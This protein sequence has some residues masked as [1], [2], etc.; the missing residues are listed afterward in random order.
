MKHIHLI[1]IGGTGLSAIAQVLL[2][3]GFTVSGSDREESALFKAVRAA[4]ASTYLGHAP[5]HIAGADLVIRSSAITDDNPEVVAA[6]KQGIPVL[7]RRDFLETLTAGKDTLAIAG[8]HG[9]TT[10][11]AMLIWILHSLGT[12]PSFIS[13]GVVNQLG[14]NA[15][16]GTGPYF[17]IEADEYDYMFL[18]LA[19]KIAIVTNIEHDHPDCFPTEADYQA[20]FTAFIERVLPDGKVLLCLDDPAARSLKETFTSTEPELLGYGRTGDAAYVAENITIVDGFPHFD[21]SHRDGQ[22][23]LNRLGTVRLSVPGQH[24]VLNATAALGVIHLLNLSISDAIQTLGEFTG[25]GRRFEVLGQ[26]LG[27]TVIDDYGHHPSEI[28]ATLEAAHSRYSGQRIWAVWQPH[29]YSRTQKLADRFIQAIDLADRV[30][31]L[32]VY[33]ARENN[34]GYS[35]EQITRSLPAGKAQYA[36]DFDL[37]MNDLLINLVSGDVVVFFS[38]GDATQLSQAVLHGLQER[39]KGA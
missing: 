25:A 33:A 32:K 28:A 37:A 22:G 7:K 38:A 21:L 5:E 14:S 15:H 24:N 34:P 3:R 18:G 31:V 30:T 39:E 35:A 13:G 9:K 1:G 26:A 19:P 17:V 10:T 8:S 23:G 2:E 6:L 11:T 29:T 27:V 20:A 4:G 16:A 12:D 36:P